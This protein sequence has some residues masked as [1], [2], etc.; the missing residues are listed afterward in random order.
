MLNS[1]TFKKSA[2]IAH[3]R[4]H[5][6]T[7]KDTQTHTKHT[8]DSKKM[9][10]LSI[11]KACEAANISRSNMYKNYINTGKLTVNRDKQNRPYIDTSE[12]W[13]VFETLTVSPNDV[14]EDTG[15]IQQVTPTV[16]TQDT[17]IRY[18]RQ[19]LAEKDTQIKAA[20]DREKHLMGQVE[21]YQLLLE[22]QQPATK[23]KQ[24]SKK[25]G[26]LGRVVAAALEID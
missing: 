23:P 4:Q 8:T 3:Q 12:L 13:R 7:S 24:P 10:R 1:R 25:R 6:N 15:E 20:S 9:A 5:K 21:R 26:L 16:D 11:K 2:I 18:L 22:H 17:E 14:R 19:L